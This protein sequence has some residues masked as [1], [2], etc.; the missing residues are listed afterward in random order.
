MNKE[1]LPEPI[2]SGFFL[3]IL[4]GVFFASLGIILM[5]TLFD[6]PAG[7]LPVPLPALCIGVG[8]LFVFLFPLKVVEWFL[9]LSS[10]PADAGG[11]LRF[12][13][14]QLISKARAAT[15]VRITSFFILTIAVFAIVY[16]FLGLHKVLY[17]EWP[18]FDSQ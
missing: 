1:Q 7:L 16:F 8:S 17:F 4:Y 3:E 15:L 18:L 13:N 10:G 12:S 2:D 6:P 5:F 11:I 9:H 14:G